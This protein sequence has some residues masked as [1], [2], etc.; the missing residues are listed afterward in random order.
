[1]T[2]LVEGQNFTVLVD[3]GAQ[4]STMNILVVQKLGCP[5]HTL[6]TILNIERTGGGK[7]PYLGYTELELQIPEIKVFREG[8]LFLIIEDNPSGDQVL[9]QLG[10]IQIDRALE[11]VT[12]E[13]MSH[14]S[15]H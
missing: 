12:E 2:V 10:T 13:E 11:L 8:A 6:Q 9:I 3:S 1:M 5:L 7:V 4:V 14:L 15:M